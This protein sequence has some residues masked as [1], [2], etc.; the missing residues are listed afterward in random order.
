V[1][2]DTWN[3]LA[4]VVIL[5]LLVSVVFAGMLWLGDPDAAGIAGDDCCE[6]E[7]QQQPGDQHDN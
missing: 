6:N 2:P 7:Q 4:V 5:T 1:S 3:T